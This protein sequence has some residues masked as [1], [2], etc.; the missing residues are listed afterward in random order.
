MEPESPSIADQKPP[1]RR[2]YRLTPDRLVL[3]VLGV[4][5]FLVLSEWFGWFAFNGQTWTVLIALAAVGL[6]LLLMLLWFVAALLFR[7]RF[8]Y[9]IRS[10]ML[11]V[12]A[13]AIPCSWLAVEMR[14]ERRQGAATEAVEEMTGFVGA[15]RTWLGLLLRDESL[16]NV[17][18]VG[19]A[20]AQISD[21]DLAHLQALTRLK[22]LSLHDTPVTDAGLVHLQGLSQL[23]DLSLGGT[24]VTDAGLVRLRGL[25]NL[26]WLNLTDSKVTAEGVKKLQQALPN[27]EI[28]R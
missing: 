26:G 16:V 21:T 2:W 11:L 23:Q 19:L 20:T 4:E 25:R 18:I 24:K 9:G 6:T 1:A 15:E 3:G 28:E 13:V 27:C 22:V 5:G 8:Q 10:L 14:N 12:V 17:T 7:W